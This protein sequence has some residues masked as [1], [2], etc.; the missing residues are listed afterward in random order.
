MQKRLVTAILALILC[1]SV[2]V[3]LASGQGRGGAR[4]GGRGARG[5]GGLNIP[6]LTITSPAFQD[7]AIIPADSP[8][9]GRGGMSPQLNWTN[10]P[11]GTASFALILHDMDVAFNG[12]TADVLHWI[13]WNIPGDAT[14][15]PSGGVPPGTVQ[16]MG[17]FG[18]MYFGPAAPAGER[19]HH[20]T[21]EL[22]ALNSTLDLPAT[23]GRPE[24]LAAMEGKVV[25][26]AAFVGRFHQ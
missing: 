23:A 20:Y 3:E 25:A 7:G 11:D 24:L 10:V 22:Y 18:N 26:K 5:G 9:A 4:G 6:P 14:G 8:I 2:G 19:Y 15:L 1:V 13:L 12:A 21:F 16:G 17:Q